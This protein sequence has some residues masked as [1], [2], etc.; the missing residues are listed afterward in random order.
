MPLPSS[1]V[2]SVVVVV[3]GLFVASSVSLYSLNSVS[4]S[5]D[6]VIASGMLT[7]KKIISISDSSRTCFAAHDGAV[8]LYLFICFLNFCF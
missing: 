6:Y 4:H 3:L 8:G 7:F 5:Y 1:W 2:S